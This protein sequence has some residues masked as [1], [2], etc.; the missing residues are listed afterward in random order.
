MRKFGCNILAVVQQYDIITESPV[1]SAMIG[2]PRCSS[3][4]DSSAQ[5]TEKPLRPDRCI[6]GLFSGLW[7]SIACYG[8]AGEQS[9]WLQPGGHNLLIIGPI[10]RT[11]GVRSTWKIQ[12]PPLMFRRW[13]AFDP[14]SRRTVEWWSKEMFTDRTLVHSDIIRSF[15]KQRKFTGVKVKSRSS[16]ASSP[17]QWSE[18]AVY[19]HIVLHKAQQLRT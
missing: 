12:L 7:N 5:V 19:T 8:P 3:P 10:Y 1:R 18:S 16:E 15:L 17:Y 14:H 2:T 13:H 9:K 11:S 6:E 4:L